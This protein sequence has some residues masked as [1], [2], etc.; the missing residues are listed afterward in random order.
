MCST[1]LYVAVIGTCVVFS[2]LAAEGVP[3]NLGVLGDVFAQELG[4]RNTVY[5][6]LWSLGATLIMDLVKY[7][8][9]LAVDGTTEEIDVERVEDAMKMAEYT[10]TMAGAHDPLINRYTAKAL[11]QRAGG[12]PGALQ[13][14]PANIRSSNHPGGIA[15]S[16]D[17]AFKKRG[18]HQDS[19]YTTT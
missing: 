16:L 13:I 8:W 3:K 2:I 17:R 5:V 18:N 14:G 6:W 12:I 1:S 4:W 19:R 10:E 7:A 9:V 15:G 11:A